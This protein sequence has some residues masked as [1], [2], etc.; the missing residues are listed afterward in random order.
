MLSFIGDIGAIYSAL[1]G[2]AK[3]I[4]TLLRIDI[5]M[6]NH[7]LNEVFMERSLKHT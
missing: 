3:L 4:L 5:M 6:E 2:I 7:L 1:A